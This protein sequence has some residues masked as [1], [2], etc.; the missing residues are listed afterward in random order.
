[1][2]VIREQ[3]LP[4]DWVEQWVEELQDLIAARREPQI[5]AHLQ[6][7]VPEYSPAERLRRPPVEAMPRYWASGLRSVS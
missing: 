5:I 1:M 4:W 2:H 3:P 6:T 7:M